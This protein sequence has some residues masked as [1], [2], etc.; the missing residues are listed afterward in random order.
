[1]VKTWFPG[2]AGAELFGYGKGA[3]R[4]GSF[5]GVF[6]RSQSEKHCVHFRGEVVWRVKLEVIELNGV[7]VLEGLQRFVL[8]L[9]CSVFVLISLHDISLIHPQLDVVEFYNS[10]I[11]SNT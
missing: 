11:S 8:W 10:V 7:S 3:C 6:G 1:M 4:R 5:D 9:M 2:G